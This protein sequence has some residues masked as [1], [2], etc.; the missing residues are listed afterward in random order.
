MLEVLGIVSDEFTAPIF[1]VEEIIKEKRSDR[2]KEQEDWSIR[3]TGSREP[4]AGQ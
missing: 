2:I 3:I 4:R 1:S